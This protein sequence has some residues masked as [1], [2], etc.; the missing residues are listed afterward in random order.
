MKTRIFGVV[1]AA[2]VLAVI[3]YPS[4]AAAQVDTRIVNI[5][6]NFHVNNTAYPAGNYE[7]AYTGQP[8]YF[9]LR[10]ADF[11]L[12]QFL[13]GNPV[14]VRREPSMAGLMFTR[15]G[16]KY[17]LAQIWVGD[18]GGIFP[19]STMEREYASQWQKASDSTVVL[20]LRK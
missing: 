10:S 17:F 4:P 7:I 2:M 19:K 5:P 12:G 14:D 16:E 6:F 11:K 1:L 8:R 3:A 15:Y 20:A 18:R 9:I 13:Y